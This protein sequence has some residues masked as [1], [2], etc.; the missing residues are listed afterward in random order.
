MITILFPGECFWVMIQGGS[1]H[2]NSVSLSGLKKLG[3]NSREDKT[4]RIHRTKYQR[5]E[6]CKRENSKGLWRVPF[7]HLVEYSSSNVCEKTIQGW[8]KNYQ[9]WLCGNTA[10]SSYVKSS[11]SFQQPWVEKLIIQGVSVRALKRSCLSNGE[12]NNLKLNASLDSPIKD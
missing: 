9:T 4:V 12:K 2:A 8:E 6:S 1:N 10:W 3:W 7:R 5:E 11:A